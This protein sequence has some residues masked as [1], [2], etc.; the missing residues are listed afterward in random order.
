MGRL[1]AY[2]IPP[3][4]TT[5]RTPLMPHY[6]S[7]LASPACLIDFRRILEPALPEMNFSPLIYRISP[8]IAPRSR[9]RAFIPAYT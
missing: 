9:R 1:A 4:F 7:P 3:H 8:A 6:F 5:R 2:A